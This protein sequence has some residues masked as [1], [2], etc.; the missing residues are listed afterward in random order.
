MFLSWKHR[1]AR[2]AVS[3]SEKSKAQNRRR[4]A[5]RIGYPLTTEW[6]EDRIAPA[7]TLS[8]PTSGFSG[9]TNTTVMN[10]PISISALT[11]GTHVGLGS[12]NFEVTTAV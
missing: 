1:L 2:M 11:D 4:L 7:A 8:L 6:L 12:A 9:A 10:F 3:R 5:I